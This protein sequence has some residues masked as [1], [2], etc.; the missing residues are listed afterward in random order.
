MFQNAQNDIRTE[1]LKAKVGEV[2]YIENK[3]HA[4]IKQGKKIDWISLDEFASQLYGRKVICEI[5]TI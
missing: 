1:R 4:V 2:I 5:K 3:P